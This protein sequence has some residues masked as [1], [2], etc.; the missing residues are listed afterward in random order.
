M[1]HGVKSE[2]TV[3][4][5]VG[6]AAKSL[7]SQAIQ[8][9]PRQ[10]VRWY[11]L[12]MAASFFAAILT[13]GT[14]VS[15]STNAH[16]V[17]HNGFD[18]SDASVPASKI[19]RGGPPRDG[20]P[21]LTNPDF[22]P[23]DEADYLDPNDR[24]MGVIIGGKAKAYPIGIL[25]WHEIV[26]DSI[27]S[28]HYAVTWCPLCGSGVVFASNAGEDHAL[29][30]GVS[31]LLYNS[32]VLLFDRQ[33]ESLWSQLKGEA[34][35]GELKGTKL[36]V[37]PVLHTTWREWQER[38]PDSLVLDEDTGYDRIDYGRD[39]YQGYSRTGRLYFEV[40]HKAPGD[41]HPKEQVLGVEID[42]HYKAWPFQELS[43]NGQKKFTDVVA[44]RE[45]EIVWNESE[46]SAYATMHDQMIPTTIA[47]WF[48]WYT[49][50]PDT[51]V[52]QTTDN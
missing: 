31:G 21:A 52:Y 39:P 30:F 14:L 9:S 4:V 18:L 17:T 29:N 5:P 23:V 19:E 44:D 48:A 36:P 43:E 32:D 25:N 34:I 50:H 7:F 49:F 28:Q 42:G 20:I 41:Y 40:D 33:T 24:V 11:W 2:L 51:E 47:F 45:I 13:V 26:N 16:A 12:S 46:R 27:D 15:V 22:V 10:P 35:S 3:A 6:L 8:S 1:N 37:L 38:Y